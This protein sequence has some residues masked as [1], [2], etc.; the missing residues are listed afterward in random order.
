ME[1]LNEVICATG[2]ETFESAGRVMNEHLCT[3][4]CGWAAP[5]SIA[6]IPCGIPGV[7]AQMRSRVLKDF[8]GGLIFE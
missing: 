1:L 3:T 4:G 7:A 8:M 5:V 6:I 2:L